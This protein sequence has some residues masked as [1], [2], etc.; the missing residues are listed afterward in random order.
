MPIRWLF[1]F[2][3]SSWF[4]FGKHRTG[5]IERK[6]Q[7][8]RTGGRRNYCFNGAKPGLVYVADFKSASASY[9]SVNTRTRQNCAAWNRMPP[10]SKQA[11]ATSNRLAQQDEKR[12]HVQWSTGNN[13][14]WTP[15]SIRVNAVVEVCY[16]NYCINPRESSVRLKLR[17]A[18][19]PDVHDIYFD[20]NEVRV[21]LHNDPLAYYHDLKRA[22][23]P[24]T[25]PKIRPVVPDSKC[26]DE[27]SNPFVTPDEKRPRVRWCASHAGRVMWVGPRFNT[28][29][30]EAYRH[31][32]TH[33]NDY[34]VRFARGEGDA[35]EVL[36]INFK[37]SELRTRYVSNN[38]VFY[39]TLHRVCA[40]ARAA[41][42]HTPLL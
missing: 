26:V 32:C 11:D 12:P 25:T 5:I 22:P 24:M 31:Y 14:V 17:S 23:T 4:A 29:C 41:T 10:D 34:E 35:H 33:P 37:R 18:D 8:Y 13:D 16:Q 15:Y 39:R 38:L 6:Y 7:Q 9:T 36:D 28:A 3:N 40:S 1:R 27:H 19:Q 21:V 20:R 2:R 42:Q 30:E